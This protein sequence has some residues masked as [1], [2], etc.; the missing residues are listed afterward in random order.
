MK[1]T[2][3]RCCVSKPFEN[4]FLI[5]NNLR[6]WFSISLFD[7]Y[8][9]LGWEDLHWTFSQGYMPKPIELYSY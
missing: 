6:R 3:D 9:L 5:P 4:Y 7:F 2:R 8:I 1:E